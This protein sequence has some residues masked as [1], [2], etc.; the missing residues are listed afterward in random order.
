MA[1]HAEDVSDALVAQAG[2]LTPE[3]LL[4]R[5]DT[6]LVAAALRAADLARTRDPPAQ[7]PVDVI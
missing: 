4:G 6:D 3:L 5:V 1:L 7:R 2:Q